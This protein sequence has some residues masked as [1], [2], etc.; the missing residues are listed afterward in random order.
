MIQL[1]VAVFPDGTQALQVREYINTTVYAGIPSLEQT[2]QSAKFEWSPW[3]NVP[4]VKV[5]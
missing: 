3:K 1:R 4:I 5:E 2:L